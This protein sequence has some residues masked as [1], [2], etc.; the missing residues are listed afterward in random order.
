M[1][2][3][4]NRA[5]E[6]WPDTFVV[7]QSVTRK[8]RADAAIPDDVLLE[9]AAERAKDEGAVET[10]PPELTWV[11]VTGMNIEWAHAVTHDGRLQYG[12]WVATI[13]VPCR[14]G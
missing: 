14:R 5:R 12:D 3:A 9:M 13:R 6:T 10:G 8:D 2:N 4:A 7:A 11:A 1:N